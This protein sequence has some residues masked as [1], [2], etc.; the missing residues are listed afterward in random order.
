MSSRFAPV[1]AET[2]VCTTLLD[3]ATQPMEVAELIAWVQRLA[4]LDL[5]TS[6]P[7]LILHLGRL[8]ASGMDP[9]TRYR[10][11]RAIKRPLLKAGA[12]LPK[13]DYRGGGISVEQRLYGAMVR[14][15]ETLQGDL[16]RPQRLAGPHRAEQYDWVVRNRLRFLQRE[17]LYAVRVGA[18][19][20]PGVWQALHDLYLYLT[21]RGRVH[22][23]WGAGDSLP[24]G[25]DAELAY[26]W[27]LM[28]GLATDRRGHR[29]IDGRAVERIGALAKDSRLVEPE[30]LVGEYGLILVEIGRDAPARIKTGPLDDPFR[31]W[32]LRTPA[33]F[34]GMLAGVTLVASELRLDDSES[35]E[36]VS[37][38]DRAC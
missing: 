14:N 19:W 37:S 30:G 15:L 16:D 8:A 38:L 7:A 18:P 9:E 31:G 33:A 2:T 10:V 3:D 6:V 23:G 22:P 26:K 27:T 35:L 1:L 29:H 25:F 17:L 20:P 36:R 28:I 5:R 34:R 32:V 11:L 13:P 12:M 21:L 4:I 24:G